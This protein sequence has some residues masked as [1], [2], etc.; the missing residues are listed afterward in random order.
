MLTHCRR[1]STP[2]TK[3]SQNPIDTVPIYGL[4]RMKR[5]I[6][7]AFPELAEFG[8]TDSRVRFTFYPRVKNDGLLMF[9]AMLVY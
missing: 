4:S 1:I 5:V 9:T 8:F 7:E 2:R 6:H 3:Y